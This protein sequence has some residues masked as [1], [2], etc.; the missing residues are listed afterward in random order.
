MSD[1]EDNKQPAF[2]N[3]VRQY[4]DV[5]VTMPWGNKF[6]T[7]EKV[8]TPAEERRGDIIA[9]SIGGLAFLGLISTIIIGILAR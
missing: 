3:G 1:T 4:R 6:T 2:I 5:N 8:L 7:Y 9:L